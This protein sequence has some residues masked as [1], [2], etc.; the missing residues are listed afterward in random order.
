[1][2]PKLIDMQRIPTLLVL[3]LGSASFLGAAHLPGGN[4]TYTCLGSNQYDVRLELFR[5]CS[6]AAMIPQ[7]LL[8]ASS[9]GTSFTIGSLNPVQVVEVSQLCPADLAN[10][11]CNGGTLP[12]IELNVFTTTVTLSP[13]ALW[14]I[15]W[16]LCCRQ[17]S[18]NLQGTPGM[19]IEARMNNLAAPC[20]DSPVFTNQSVPY[21]CVNDPVSYNY[22]VSDPEGNTLTYTFI[23]GRV[24]STTP[25][26]YQGTLNGAMPYPGMTLDTNTGQIAFTPAGIGYIFTAMRVDQFDSTG[27]FIGSVMS[28]LAFVV[29]ACPNSA[30]DPVSG[31]L[32][33]TSGQAVVVDDRTLELCR[34]EAICFEATMVDPD[35][36]Q[37]LT[38]T[39]NVT[40]AL[41]GAT[42]QQ[43]G[44]NPATAEI[45]WNSGGNMAGTYAFVITAEDDACPNTAVQSYAYEV[46]VLP[47]DDAG[48]DGTAT[49]C[50]NSPTIFLL[51][52][53]NGTPMVGGTW[54]APNNIPHSGTY[55]VGTDTPG[56]YCYVVD[57]G[58]QCGAD[59]ACVTVT[60]LPA[61]DPAC[62]STGI[63]STSEATLHLSPNPSS[64]TVRFS[65]PGTAVGDVLNLEVID[66]TGRSWA[67]R[68]LDVRDATLTITLPETIPSGAYVLRVSDGHGRSRS[69][70]LMLRR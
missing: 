8:F 29:T 1:M 37:S 12:G 52:S 21:V 25:V 51:D 31:A 24:N 20:N 50:P 19:Y 34:G 58:N 63:G 65:V 22:A 16:E 46:M 38:L 40:S 68:A 69:E 44:T 42:F 57:N 55:L 67:T 45:C 48:A 61:N 32:M 47:Q 27:T 60:E 28:D 56:V 5:E 2:R 39:S 64:G 17:N 6:G 13:C 35:A 18:L 66:L 59:T 49:Y 43:N 7:E 23:D 70:Q 3:F 11:T 30:P 53:L 62:L 33:L 41:P 36:S 4:I 9:C 14:T 10:S 15:S 26:T 54:Y